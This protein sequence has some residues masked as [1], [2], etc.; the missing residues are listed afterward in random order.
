[1][2]MKPGARTRPL[3]SIS[4]AAVSVRRG[5]TAEILPSRTATSRD[6][7]A[8]PLPSITVAP[9]INK[10]CILAPPPNKRCGAYL[11]TSLSRALGIAFSVAPVVFC[12]EVWLR[13]GGLGHGVRNGI[14]Q[15]REPRD[16]QHSQARPS[17][18]QRPDG[19]LTNHR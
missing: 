19:R 12:I 11:R 7:G 5:S 6:R 14:P 3:A 8:P 2:S 17:F 18:G 10:S 1:M 4:C 16:Q 13:G 9:R 15:R